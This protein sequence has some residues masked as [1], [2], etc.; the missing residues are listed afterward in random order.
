MTPQ[1]LYDFLVNEWA[2]NHHLQVR[3]DRGVARIPAI[4]RGMHELEDL[5]AQLHL[6]PVVTSSAETEHERTFERRRSVTNG[7]RL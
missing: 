5:R 3:H 7:D 1:R 2:K 6:L 4:S